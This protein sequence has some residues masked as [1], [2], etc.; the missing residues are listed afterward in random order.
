MRNSIQRVS[1]S[2]VGYIDIS[3]ASED[4]VY[5]Q[6]GMLK[7]LLF[8]VIP[9][10]PYNH[11]VGNGGSKGWSKRTALMAVPWKAKMICPM[12]NVGMPGCRCPITVWNRKEMFIAHRQIYHI[13]QHAS[14]ILCEHRNNDN[15]PCHY[16]TDREADMKNHMYKLHEAAVQ[17]KIAG[18][19]Y[20]K[21]NAWLD[22][23]S[24]WSIKY[25]ERSYKTFRGTMYDLLVWVIMDTSDITEKA[26]LPMSISI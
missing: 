16:M 1:S 6:I 24:S 25:L 20:V 26:F 19:N 3:V 18:N 21:E 12:T 23:T 5:I 9:L 17:E 14:C 8:D 22:L 4:I 11:L 13:D 15:V 10:S 2:S 7:E